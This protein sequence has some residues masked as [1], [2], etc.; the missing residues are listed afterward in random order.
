MLL[1]AE[2]KAA[3]KNF[4]EKC[5]AEEEGT[6]NWGSKAPNVSIVVIK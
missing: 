1:F 5:I 3:L 2:Q 6:S 4:C